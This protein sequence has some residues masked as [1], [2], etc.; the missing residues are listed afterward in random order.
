MKS[1]ILHAISELQRLYPPAPAEPFVRMV[2]GLLAGTVLLGLLFY[3]LE[4][5]F[6]EQ[7]EQ[8]ALRAGT[9]VDAIYWFFDFFIARR[10]VTAVTVIVLIGVVA[11]KMPRASLWLNSPSGCRRWRRCWW[12]IFAGTGRTA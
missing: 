8:R 2:L 9:K 6:P 12:P 4:R 11:L 10:L 5:L 7:R 3:L 1:A